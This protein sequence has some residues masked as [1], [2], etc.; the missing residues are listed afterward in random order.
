MKNNKVKMPKAN[1][2]SQYKKNKTDFPF[3]VELCK[4]SQHEL[5]RFLPMKLSDYGYKN[6]IVE[7]GYIYAKGEVPVLLTAHMDTVHK[8]RIIDYYETIKDGKHI[9]TSPQGIGG[10]DRCGIYIILQIIQKFKCSVLFCE[11]EEI[12]AIG[13]SRFCKTKFIEDVGDL[14]Y[15]IGLDREGYKDAVF[16]DCNN[17]KFTDYIIKNTG[18][19]KEFGSFSDISIIAPMCGVS[20]VNLSCGYYFAHSKSEQIIVEDMLNTIE[21]VKELLKCKSEKFEYI[22][23]KELGW[24]S[25]GRNRWYYPKRGNGSIELFEI[26]IH[27]YLE[28]GEVMCDYGYGPSVL[29]AWTDFFMNNPEVSFDDIS[30]YS[31]FSY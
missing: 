2:T 16:Y 21:V 26:R 30:D 18:F 20:A 27:F 19:T 15:I 4:L 17:P 28:S 31:V 24:G 25:W 14:N 10:D 12:G 3:L 5:T 29:E 11:D 13:S 9:L 7:D 22:E 1:E 8:Q 23:D 6:I